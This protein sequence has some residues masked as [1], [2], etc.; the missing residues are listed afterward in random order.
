MS[1]RNVPGTIYTIHLSKPLGPSDRG[2]RNTARH[3][4][5]WTGNLAARIAEH[6]EG[7]GSKL[8]AAAKQRGID[9][10]VAKTEP[11]TRARERQLKKH[12]AARRCP[13]CKKEN[14]V[15]QDKTTLGELVTEMNA[16][17][18][19]REAVK[20]AVTEL[21]A[22]GKAIHWGAEIRQPQAEAEVADVD[23]EMG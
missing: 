19:S 17:T 1:Q 12:S 18:G 9:W 3:Y 10:V 14:E 13:E 15:Q 6:R 2:P 5:G 11:G 23:L 16:G 8:L 20:A 7:Y 21:S 4:T 22:E